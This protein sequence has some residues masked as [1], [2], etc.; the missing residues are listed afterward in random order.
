M[1]RHLQDQPADRAVQLPVAVQAV[2]LP[3]AA[4]AVQLPA[5]VREADFDTYVTFYLDYEKLK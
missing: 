5:V 1:A 3:V 4:Q 2:Q